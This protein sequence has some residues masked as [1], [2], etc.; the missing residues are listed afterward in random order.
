MLLFET[1]ICVSC[2]QFGIDFL[3]FRL[4]IGLWMSMFLFILVVFNL[5]FLV[6]FVTRFTEDCFTTLVATIFIINSFKNTINLRSEKKVFKNK[7]IS[8]D[9]ITQSDLKEYLDQAEK[10]AVFYFSFILFFT[11]FFICVLLKSFEK[12][13]FLT[14]K[15]IY[16]LTKNEV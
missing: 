4:W 7:T 13:P 2:D 14:S 5:S 1:I 9:N 3:E 6:R 8:V 16:I 15:V 11:T 10:E 12:K